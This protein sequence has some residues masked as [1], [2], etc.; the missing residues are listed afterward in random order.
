MHRII[1]NIRLQL[2]REKLFYDIFEFSNVI[3]I[4]KHMTNVWTWMHNIESAITIN[5]MYHISCSST[6]DFIN[7]YLLLAYLLTFNTF[8]SYILTIHI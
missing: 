4:C 8:Q 6:W 7:G 5:K 1:A 2:Y 3:N